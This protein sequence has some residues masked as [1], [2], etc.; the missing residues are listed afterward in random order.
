MK[1]KRKIKINLSPLEKIL[2]YSF[3]NL[4]LLEQA[5]SHRSYAKKN[6]ER[7]EFLG[8]SLLSMF[9][10][11][12]VYHKFP[13][14]NEGELSRLRSYLVKGETLAA[15]AREFSLGEYLFLGEGELKS[16]GFRRSS[17]LEDALESTIG[18]IYLDSDI[19]CCEASV[20]RWF[21]TRLDELTMAFVEKDPKTRLQEY[22]QERGRKLP[23]YN[24]VRETGKSHVREYEV[25]VDLGEKFPKYSAVA[26]SKRVAE[27]LA[28]IAILE[29]LEGLKNV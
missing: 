18:A 25:E 10:A 6:Y 11:D 24:V 20:L 22:L 15:L 14:A 17:I 12:A 28:A 8:D 3:N 19:K 5:L 29:Y 21:S 26:S 27:K 7:L 23:N 16:G 2:G 1:T 9:M 13:Q 4:S